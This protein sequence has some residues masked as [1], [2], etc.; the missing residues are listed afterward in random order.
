MLRKYES[1]LVIEPT[2]SEEMANA[3]IE[4]VQKFIKENGGEVLKVDNWGKRNLAYEIKKFR[5][6]YMCVFYFNF[7]ADNV[8]EYERIVKLNEKIIRNNILV[9]S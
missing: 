1:M 6:G 2:I 5:E 4:K 8:L 7:D 9:K 3:E